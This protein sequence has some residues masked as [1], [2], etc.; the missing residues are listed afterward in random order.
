MKFT[1]LYQPELTPSWSMKVY[2]EQL[3]EEVNLDIAQMSDE[4]DGT[5]TFG[6]LDGASRGNSYM[7][8]VDKFRISE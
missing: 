1:N 3:L 6:I 2:I 8:A 4:E 7:Q 5:F